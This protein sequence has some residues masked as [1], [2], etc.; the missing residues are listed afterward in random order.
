MPAP[1][2]AEILRRAKDAFRKHARGFVVVLDDRG[3]LH[4]G[5]LPELE[6]R[7]GNHSDA[8]TL[9]HAAIIAVEIYDP[10]REAVVEKKGIRPHSNH[11]RPK[12]AGPTPRFF[13]FSPFRILL[14]A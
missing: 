7:L 3:E 1:D 8:R 10:D 11:A 6:E 14:P 5:F 2:R 9:I 13:P 4:Y 12:Y